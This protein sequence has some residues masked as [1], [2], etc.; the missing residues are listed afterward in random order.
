VGATW[1]LPALLAWGLGWL[2]F[3]VLHLATLSLPV[4]IGAAV[5]AGAALTV[6]GST[7]WRR[8]FIALGFLLSLTVSGAAGAIPSWAWLLPLALLAMLYPINAWRDA[9]LFP[10]PA[11]ALRDLA[12]VAPLPAGALL[13]DAGCGMGDGLRELRR[14][15]P[16]AVLHGLEWSWPLRL[17][18][19]WR[20]RDARVRRADIWPV[21]WSPYALVYLFQR[22]ESMER[23]AAKA[24]RELR[25]GAWLAS[26]EFDVPGLAPTKVLEC[27]DGR[28]LW[29]YQVP[30]RVR[31]AGLGI[32]PAPALPRR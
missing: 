20:C 8:A 25:P 1:P 16:N 12:Q 28:R 22:P 26:L 10:T 4:A 9:P 32:K 27:A 15:Y 30:F 13:L 7:A 6:L 29:L 11:E 31:A 18:C 14:E 21:D 23:A 24:L 3:E 5:V 17:A 19:A 2:V